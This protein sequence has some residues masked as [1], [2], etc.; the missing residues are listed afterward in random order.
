M[1]VA[2]AILLL[3]AGAAFADTFRIHYSIRGSGR[4]VTVNL[5]A[6]A[7]AR[8]WPCFPALSSPEFTA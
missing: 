1:K 5:P 2:T 8:S 3:L 6:K 4:D 7:A